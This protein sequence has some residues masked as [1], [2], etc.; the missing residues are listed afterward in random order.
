MDP[1]A[2][3]DR[4]LSALRHG[5]LEEAREASSDLS[6]WLARGGFAPRRDAYARLSSA[7]PDTFLDELEGL[8]NRLRPEDSDD[9]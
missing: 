8:L 1:N 7:A 2:C 6:G 3:V 9:L 4:I 5:D